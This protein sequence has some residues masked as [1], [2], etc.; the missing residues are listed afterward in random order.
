MDRVA[1]VA[2]IFPGNLP[3]FG[4]F[5]AS[6]EMQTTAD[7]DLIIIN[8]GAGDLTGV[9]GNKSYLIKDVIILKGFPFEIRVK[10]IKELTNR[11]YEKLIFSDTDDTLSSNRVKVV[12]EALNH[13][14]IVCNDLDILNEE[15]TVVEK[16]YW[17]RRLGENFI[18]EPAFL[19]D[20]N[21]IGFGNCGIRLDIELPSFR[22]YPNIM[23]PDWIFFSQLVRNEKKALFTA[24]GTVGYRQHSNNTIGLKK[25]TQARILKTI[26]CKI[27]FYSE[28]VKMG[29]SFEQE[30]QRHLHMKEAALNNDSWVESSLNKIR[31]ENL[32]LFWW[33]ETNTLI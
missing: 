6:V 10:A 22:A 15:G 16:N 9:I 32:N 7:F 3:F 24:Q 12:V 14:S 18:I 13:Y 1:V 4:S 11:G 19:V 2:V 31:K 25:V 23:A 33:E 20:K 17:S 29:Y 21:I 30:L 27:E 8:D 28:L 5:L 26:N